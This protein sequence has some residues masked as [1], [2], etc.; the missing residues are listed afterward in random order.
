MKLTY[1]LKIFIIVFIILSLISFVNTAG[2]DVTTPAKPKKLL[3]AVTIEGLVSSIAINANDAF[4]ESQRGSSG[5]L[6]GSCGKL[7]KNNCTST[8]CCVW[9]SDDKCVAGDAGGPTFNT[10]ADG[11]TNSIDYYF[12]HNKCHGNKCPKV[13]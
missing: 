12:F 3:Q 5:S 1:I 11:K 2:V 10:G 9:T 7:T 13:V 4:C 6:D 8:S